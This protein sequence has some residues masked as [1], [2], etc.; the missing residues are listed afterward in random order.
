MEHCRKVASIVIGKR[1][2]SGALQGRP[3]ANWA[4]QPGV[5]CEV[6]FLNF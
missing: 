6:T 3:L 2:I 1:D 5:P 4:N